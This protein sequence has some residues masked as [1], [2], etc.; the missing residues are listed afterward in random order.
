MS[1]LIYFL[2]LFF[3]CNQ[4][5]SNIPEID[6]L[7]EPITW[8]QWIKMVNYDNFLVHSMLRE[9]LLRGKLK[10]KKRKRK[11]QEWKRNLECQRTV[12]Y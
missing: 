12:C 4:N 8:I 10:R 5:N 2:K 6:V 7:R 9:V 1:L 3:T 11:I